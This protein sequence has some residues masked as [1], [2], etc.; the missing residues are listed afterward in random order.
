MDNV[1]LVFIELPI[2]EFLRLGF[3]YDWSYLNKVA[4]R[5]QKK[6]GGLIVTD[7]EKI[8]EETCSTFI[9]AEEKFTD[10]LRHAEK[11]RKLLTYILYQARKTQNSYIL[12][13]KKDA[14]TKYLLSLLVI[15]GGLLIVWWRESGKI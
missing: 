9:L 8:L 1:N 7:I 5:V 4:S 11:N 2:K 6:V 15:L 12:L 3:V 13:V 14:K 10:S